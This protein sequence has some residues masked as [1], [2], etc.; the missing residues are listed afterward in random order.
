MADNVTTKILQIQVDYGD[1][2][3]QIA[4]WQ[5]KI[6]AVRKQ[7]KGLKDDLKEGR[8]SQEEYQRSIQAGNLAMSQMKDAMNTVSKAVKNQLKSQAEQEGSLV[9]LRAEISNLNAEYDRLSRAERESAKGDELKDKINRLTTEL[10]SAEEG[11][12]RFYR[13][14]GNYKSALLGAGVST[15]SLCDALSKEAKSA[16]EAEKANEVLKKAV[17][18]IDPSSVGASESIALLTKKIEENDKIIKEHADNLAAAQKKQAEQS[19]GLIDTM[20][21][22][23]GVNL[24]FGN[25]LS[26]LSK[27]SAGSVLQGLNVKAKALWATLTGLL[28]NPVV[29]TFLGIAGAGM[30]FKWWYDYNKGLVEATRRTQEFTGLAG[31]DLKAFRN[32]VQGV[33]DSFGVDFMEVLESANAMSQ[34]FGISVQEA[35]QYIKDGFVSGANIT[36]QFTDML[37]EYPAYFKEAG[38]SA[39]QFVSIIAQSSKMGIVSDKAV[40]TI[41]EANIRLREMSTAT[42]EAL[43]GIGI[44]SAEMQKK[45]QEGT[46]STFE[47]MQQVSA[48]LNEISDNSPAVAAAISDI[49]GG[50]GEDAGLQYLRTLKDIELDLDTT[51][52]KA[53]DLAK[54]QEEQMNSQIELDNTLAAIFDA[55]GGTFEK[56]T[57]TAKIWVNN[58]IVA[59]IKGCAEL[60]NWFID[61]YNNSMV[62]RAGVASIAIQFKTAWSIIKNVCI[63]LVDEIIGLGKILKGTLTLNWD[64]V[65][66]GWDQF[67][68]ASSNAVRNIVN[69]TVDAYKEAW[70]EIKDGQ[71]EH[72]NLDI[73]ST[74]TTDNGN[75][76]QT[77]GGGTNKKPGKTKPKDKKTGKDPAV[78]AAK[79]EAQLL[80][81]AEDELLKITIESIE[82]RRKRVELSYKRQIEDYQKKLTEEKNL[83][84]ASR[85]AILSIIDSLQKQQIQALAQFNAE[86]IKKEIEHKEKLNQLKLEAIKKGTDEEFDLRRQSLA[87][88]QSI[89]EQEAILAYDNETEKQEALKAIREKYANEN[90]ALDE[91]QAQVK[92]DRQKAELENEIAALEYAQSERELRQMRGYQMDEEQYQSWRQRGLDEMDEHQAELLS[93]QEEATAAELEALMQRGQ[94]STQ[95]TEE[96]EAEILAAKERSAEAQKRTNDTIIKN[97]Q[98]KAQALKDITG[99]LTK[100]LDTLGESNEAFAKMSKIIT[101]AQISIDTGKAL[102]AGIASASSMPFPANLAAIATTVATILANIATAIS[103]VKSAKFAQ[104]GKVTGPGT[105]TSDSI[106]AMLSNGEF[107]MT[108]AATKMFE[109]LLMTMNNIGRG[110][111]MQVL[112]SSQSINNA[113][114]LT[115]SF[116]SAAREIKPIVSVVEITEAQDRVEM[117]ENLDTY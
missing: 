70:S 90:T 60:V 8:I 78:E 62:V 2:V 34:Q 83:T 11:T 65:K 103:T 57:A 77:G 109:P 48:K 107:V 28:A 22:L 91:E 47:A 9:Q 12:Q 99:G 33:A 54:I 63:L 37:K 38:I 20:S 46:M 56:M 66:A 5:S 6:D 114:M 116:E 24:N 13:N 61:L 64:D 16:E 89:A 59:M 30:A 7:Q 19:E 87:N 117:I 55:T 113:E 97:E 44:N 3:K 96:F 98:A 92:L 29:L 10:K 4:E 14:V 49:F 100:L 32:E 76:G 18:A 25:S 86:E 101:L 80:R 27:N 68:K 85:T 73:S 79:E 42:T 67:R 52:A 31:D 104:G 1:A 35:M 111:P 93:K 102:S 45:L 41:K 71:L 75:G 84:E 51:K 43:D 40:D 69:D 39:S 82:T 81:K 110:V 94:L 23:T 15:Q 21:N 17:A 58:G 112:N 36:G 88:Q 74:S 95:T 108:A 26:N 72:V 115:D 105:G 53:G 106:P 50:P